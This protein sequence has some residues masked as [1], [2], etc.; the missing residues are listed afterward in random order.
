MII[1]GNQFPDKCPSNCKFIED[2]VFHGQNSICF[3]CPVFNCPN[4]V[5]PDNFR[6]DWSDEWFKFFDDGMKHF[7][8]LLVTPAD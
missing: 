5:D 3:R 2:V 7:P 1:A 8:M 6:Q 4:L